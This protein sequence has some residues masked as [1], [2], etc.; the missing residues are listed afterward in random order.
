MRHR[1]YG[2]SEP[3]AAPGLKAD[4]LE[5]A[6]GREA[7]RSL[8]IDGMNPR[9]N[10]YVHQQM[11]HSQTT[12]SAQACGAQIASEAATQPQYQHIKLAMDVHAAS[13]VVGSMI[14]GAK[15]QPPQTFK[16]ADFLAWAK[17]QGVAARS[18]GLLGA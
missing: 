7:A 6:A 11:S 4:C 1:G 14:D 16:P 10:R 13:I 17:K 18:L 8:L 5:F 15:P 2:P 3:S 9:R 12:N